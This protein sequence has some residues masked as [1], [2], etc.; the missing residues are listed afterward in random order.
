MNYFKQSYLISFIFLS[1]FC[2]VYA[3]RLEPLNINPL[4]LNVNFGEG[5]DKYVYP[6]NQ[7]LIAPS[8][9]PS[10]YENI[11]KYISEQHIIFVENDVNPVYVLK[12]LWNNANYKYKMF[13]GKHMTFGSKDPLKEINNG[14]I[15]YYCGKY[16]KVDFSNYPKIDVSEYKKMYGQEVLNKVI[17]ILR[18]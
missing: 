5:M 16:I 7:G 15:D 14:F 3:R 9:A 1:G 13:G 6:P 10:Q 11:P 4:H 2:L 8:I 18:S 12:V 17:D